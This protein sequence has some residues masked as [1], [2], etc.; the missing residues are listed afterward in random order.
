MERKERRG[1]GKGWGNGM[2]GRKER[3]WPIKKRGRRRRREC[4]DH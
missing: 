3:R 4:E 2:M 1:W